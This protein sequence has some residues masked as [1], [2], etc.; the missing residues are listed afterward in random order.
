MYSWLSWSLGHVSLRSEVSDGLPRCP[1][2]LITPLTWFIY[3]FS[4]DLVVPTHPSHRSSVTYIPIQYR[5]CLPI[6]W[7]CI[8]FTLNFKNYVH[9][10]KVGLKI[11]VQS[12]QR[13]CKQVDEEKG[14]LKSKVKF[15][16][17]SHTVFV[18]TVLYTVT[19]LIYN[20]INWYLN[21]KYQFHTFLAHFPPVGAIS[22]LVISE[23]CSTF[24]E[25]RLN[26]HCKLVTPNYNKMY[27]QKSLKNACNIISELTFRYFPRAQSYSFN[28]YLEDW[29]N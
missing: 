27:I 19:V 20:S 6:H 1:K 4:V 12:R 22:K 24:S 7:L 21:L 2:N 26:L 3:F 28:L 14:T 18:H 29:T 10:R 23:D 16:L 8:C 17:N 15:S 25:D 13:Q 5:K 11:W 9:I